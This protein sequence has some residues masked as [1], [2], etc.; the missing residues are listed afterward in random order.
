MRRGRSRRRSGRRMRRR[1]DPRS[2]GDHRGLGMSHLLVIKLDVARIDVLDSGRAFARAAA[3]AG[4]ASGAASAVRQRR[5]RRGQLAANVEPGQPRGCVPP[6][7]LV[8]LLLL[9]LLLLLR[10]LEGRRKLL[11]QRRL[12]LPH[13]LPALRDLAGQVLIRRH[14][15]ATQVSVEGD[16]CQIEQPHARVEHEDDHEP[17]HDRRQTVAFQEPRPFDDVGGELHDQNNG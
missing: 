4:G 12:P 13:L 1:G 10:G 8:L 3:G 14:L 5:Q 7:I 17:G 6:G 2:G 16:Q 11:V 9:L 15:H